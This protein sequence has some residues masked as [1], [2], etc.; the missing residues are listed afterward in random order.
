[1]NQQP[2]LDALLAV[3]ILQ[4][5]SENVLCQGIDIG[6]LFMRSKVKLFGDRQ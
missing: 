6:R 5:F 4:Q 3:S 2:D 1:M